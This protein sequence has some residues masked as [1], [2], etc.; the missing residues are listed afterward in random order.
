VGQPEK[1][2]GHLKDL[3]VDA[4]AFRTQNG[5]EIDSTGSGEKYM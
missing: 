4:K 1:K 3:D 2:S 5:C